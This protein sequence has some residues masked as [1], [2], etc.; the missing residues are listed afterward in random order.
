MA[1]TPKRMHSPRKQKHSSPKL[2]SITSHSPA[3]LAPQTPRS[4]TPLRRSARRSPLSLDATGEKT[5]VVE[6]FNEYVLKRPRTNA[7]DLE[8]SKTPSKAISAEPD[9]TRETCNSAKKTRRRIEKEPTEAPFAPVS[10]DLSET[11]KRKSSRNEPAKVVTRARALR[12]LEGET[13]TKGSTVLKKKVFYK[14]VV[15]DGGEFGIGDNVYVKRR[16][17]ASSD[18]EDPEVE[19]CRICFKAG[20][21]IMIECDDCLGGFHLKCLRPPLKEVPEGEW[22]CEFCEAKKMGKELEFP[23]PPEGKK[24]VR[25]AREKLLSGDLWAARI[26]R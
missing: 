17:D 16:E 23:K 26:E 15:Y 22:V 12:D 6:K 1:E 13:K 9:R 18:D 25:T 3:S 7:K 20:T 4:A 24:R 11:R 19:D 8:I 2:N 10:P 5:R 14:V 21:A